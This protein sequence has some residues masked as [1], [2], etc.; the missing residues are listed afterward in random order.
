MRFMDGMAA[1]ATIAAIAFA[2]PLGAHAGSLSVSPTTV[3]LPAAGG[4]GVLYISNR[5]AQPAMVQVESYDWNQA[6]GADRLEASRALQVSPPMAQL[7]P[8]QRQ[9]VRLLVRPGGGSEVE[10]AFRLVV[11]EL[12]NP[13]LQTVQGARVLLQFSVPVFA[14]TPRVL[15]RQLVWDASIASGSVLFAVRNDGNTRAKLVGLRIVTPKG[16]KQDIAPDSIVYVLPGA[17]RQWKF[18]APDIAAGDHLRIEG[19]DEHGGVA[20]ST[21]TVAHR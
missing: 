18:A 6:S 1:M 16:R 19:Q 15:S 21:F 11:S 5:G 17:S 20:V 13:A 3:E 4:T 10:R 7:A 14:G 2:A 8:G 9:V 12:P